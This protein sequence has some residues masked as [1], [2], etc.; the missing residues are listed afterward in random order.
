MLSEPYFPLNHV[1]QWTII[2]SETYYPKNH[3]STWTMS[4]HEPWYSMRVMQSGK[5]IESESDE[6]GEHAGNHHPMNHAASWTIL[7]RAP[8][9]RSVN[10]VAPGSMLPREPPHRYVEVR[11]IGEHVQGNMNEPSGVNDGRWNDEFLS[12]L[13]DVKCTRGR[14]LINEKSLVTELFGC[15]LVLLI[16]KLYR[17]YWL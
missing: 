2:P 16:G 13:E 5:Y 4:A 14:T 17:N 3:I 6:E 8:Y 10:R 15:A 1:T 11:M 9:Y 7:S 12:I